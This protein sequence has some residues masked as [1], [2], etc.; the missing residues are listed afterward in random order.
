MKR[1]LDMRLFFQQLFANK[2]GVFFGADV[3]V[4]AVV[5]LVLARFE[6]R[7][8]GSKPLLLYLRE[9]SDAR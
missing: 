2:I 6:R 1:G 5:V 9:D 8:L 7:R 3:L 4:S